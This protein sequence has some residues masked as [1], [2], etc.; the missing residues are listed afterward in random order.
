MRNKRRFV[1]MYV[2]DDCSDWFYA[3]WVNAKD[4]VE[5]NL[6]V[7]RLFIQQSRRGMP[8]KCILSRGVFLAAERDPELFGHPVRFAYTIGSSLYILIRSSPKHAREYPLAVRYRHNFTKMLRA[9][10]TMSKQQF[11]EHF[12]EHGVDIRL[13]APRR[14]NLNGDHV[15]SRAQPAR[16]PTERETGERRLVGA[17]LRAKEAGLL[18][19]KRH[20]PRP[21]SPMQLGA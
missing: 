7:D 8:W 10:D 13:V 11:V 15:V 12:G 2:T 14:R 6:T 21:P 9:F 18:N 20:Q 1:K 17:E 3:Q 5:F 16:A 19:K 4:S